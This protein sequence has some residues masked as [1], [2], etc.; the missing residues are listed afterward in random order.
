[1][2]KKILVILLL[3]MMIPVV[4]AQ[5]WGYYDSPSGFF[6][7]EW[8]M[9]F[10]MFIVFFAVIFYAVNRSFNNPA[11]SAVIAIAGALIITLAL[12]R[13]GVLYEYEEL[14]SWVFVIVGLIVLAFLFKVLAEFFPVVGPL[15]LAVVLWVILRFNDPY[16]MI[17]YSFSDGF[18]M[19]Y[20]FMQSIIGLI[21][22]VVLAILISFVG[23]EEDEPYIYAP[24]RK[25]KGWKR[26]FSRH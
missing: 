3:C 13:W 8:V 20:E 7:N 11:I 2:D 23:H 5:Y 12:T 9:F 19:A 14:G 21:I 17:P 16:E 22:F 24:R 4:S 18:F 15:I 10:I 25:K 1:M 6:E 26:F